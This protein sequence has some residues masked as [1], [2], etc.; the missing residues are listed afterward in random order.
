MQCICTRDVTSVVANRI[1]S[2]LSCVLTAA[3]APATQD[4]V[5]CTITGS[6]SGRRPHV[7]FCSRH[8]HNGAE[9]RWRLHCS[10]CTPTHRRQKDALLPSE[11]GTRSTRCLAPGCSRPRPRLCLNLAPSKHRCCSKMLRS[12]SPSSVP[13]SECC[14]HGGARSSFL[15]TTFPAVQT[16][17]PFKNV[18]Q[19]RALKPAGCWR[20][21]PLFSAI[22]EPLLNLL[23]PLNGAS[24]A[25]PSRITTASACWPTAHLLPVSI[26]QS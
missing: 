12:S 13:S 3:V 20:H 2:T 24:R 26:V 4:T 15:F 25:R 6:A 17:L 1:T 23:L 19:Q 16:P 11:C 7:D 10:N 8:H 5:T 14:T 22:N 9:R 18:V 21:R